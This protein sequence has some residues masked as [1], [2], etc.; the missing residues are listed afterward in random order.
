MHSLIWDALIEYASFTYSVWVIETS[1]LDLCHVGT[2]N[3]IIL[4]PAAACKVKGCHTAAG[5]ITCSTVYSGSRCVLYCLFAVCSDRPLYLRLQA[6]SQEAID[7]ESSH[8]WLTVLT[9]L[10]V[11]WAISGYLLNVT[12]RGICEINS[13]VDT[14][15]RKGWNNR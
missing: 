7:S 15:I 12:S 1:V 3:L 4:G 11:C 13:L 14:I 8:Y 10:Y 9:V 6:T 5:A 2:Q